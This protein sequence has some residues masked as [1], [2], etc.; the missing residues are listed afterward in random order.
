MYN[1]IVSMMVAA[2]IPA[3]G[4]QQMT[5]AVAAKLS[6]RQGVCA[7]CTQPIRYIIHTLFMNIIGN[8]E[9]HCYESIKPHVYIMEQT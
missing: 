2:P 5:P 4:T 7:A 8:L 9:E 1:I 3:A 6:E